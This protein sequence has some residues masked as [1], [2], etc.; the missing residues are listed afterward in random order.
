MIKFN[1]TIL[2][3]NNIKEIEEFKPILPPDSIYM[4]EEKKNRS[5]QKFIPD[6]YDLDKID[7]YDI[8]FQ[9]NSA[10]ITRNPIQLKN[11]LYN[12][13]AFNQNQKRD[14]YIESMPINVY[15]NE[16]EKNIINDDDYKEIEITKVELEKSQAYKKEKN[17]IDD[18]IK[19]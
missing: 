4:L 2:S 14:K 15:N 19:F 7:F 6:I 3:Y 10:P 8:K 13:M 12:L 1:S 16:Q 17:R 18:D 5:F 9:R 11:S